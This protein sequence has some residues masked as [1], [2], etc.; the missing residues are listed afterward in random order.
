[1]IF[2]DICQWN[3]TWILLD[4][5]I[6]KFFPNILN[7]LPIVSFK[8]TYL[9]LM[10]LKLPLDTILIVRNNLSNPFLDSLIPPILIKLLFLIQIFSLYFPFL[11]FSLLILQK[12]AQLSITV[13]YLL[14][15][16]SFLMKLQINFIIKIFDVLSLLLL[17][18]TLQDYLLFCYLV[19][20][21]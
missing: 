12:I 2:F 14:E 21:L 17:V 1:M 18:L 15:I 7:L 5:H 16:L 13:L 6:L 20:Y 8:L 9:S 4:N 3:K 11:K 10:V 19:F